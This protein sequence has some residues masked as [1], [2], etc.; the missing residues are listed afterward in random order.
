MGRLEGNNARAATAGHS[1]HAI[2]SQGVRTSQ[3]AAAPHYARI[4]FYQ[5][6]GSTEPLEPIDPD[7]RICV[8]MIQSRPIH[9]PRR[10]LS[11]RPAM[12]RFNPFASPRRTTAICAF[13]PADIDVKRS[14]GFSMVDVANGGERSLPSKDS[15]S[16]ARPNRTSF[17]CPV[18]ANRAERTPRTAP[19]G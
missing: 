1:E 7:V 17:C 19:A 11:E 3:P 6:L 10:S 12:G 16:H 8:P 13:R 2:R 4:H 14:F 15:K 9:A 5:I 18:A